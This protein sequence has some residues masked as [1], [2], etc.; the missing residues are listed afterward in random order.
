MTAREYLEGV[1]RALAAARA[2]QDAAL[3]GAPGGGGH[4]APRSGL[5]CGPTESRALALVVASARAR[6]AEAEAREAR[7]RIAGL[8]LLFSR[9]ADVLELRY[10]RGLGWDDVAAE[11]GVSRRTAIRWRDELCDWV[12]AHGWARARDGVGMAEE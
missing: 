10:L 8:R 3:F 6:A 11:L 7:A 5:P 2:A 1:S 12:D 9:K 4:D